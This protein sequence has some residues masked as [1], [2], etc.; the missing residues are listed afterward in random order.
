MSKFSA[1]SASKPRGRGPTGTTGRALTHEGGVGY[2]KDNKTA[3]YTLAVTDLVNEPT[4]YESGSDRAARLTQLVADVASE[5]PQWLAGFIPFLRNTAN[6]RS[7]SIVVAAEFAKALMDLRAANED[8]MDLSVRQ[9]IASAC[10]RAD[11]PA[12]MLG[13][14]MSAHGRRIPKGVKRGIAD[15][16]VKLYNEYGAIKY[17]GG[18]RGIRPADV[19]ELTH[20]SPQS[21]WQSALFKHLLDRRHGNFVSF[22]SEERDLLPKVASM[23]EIDATPEDGRRALLADPTRLSEAGYTWE[24]LSGW[25]PGG[26]DAK[27]W[28]AIIPS[29][30]YMALLRNLRNFEQAGVS[31]SMLKQVAA[32]LADPERVAKSRQFPYRFWSAF[33]ANEGSVMFGRELEE[34]LEASVSNIPELPG[35]TLVA[36]DT[37]G[38]MQSPV[39]GNSTTQC[40]EIAALFAH[41]VGKRSDAHIIQYADRWATA[42]PAASVLKSVQGVQQSIGSV[43]YGTATWPSVMSAWQKH[44]P[45]DRIIVFTDMQDHPA[46]AS[47][48]DHYRSRHRTPDL[49]DVPVYVW[50]LRGY[51]GSNVNLNQPGRYLFSGF[52]DAAFRLIPL[53]EHGLNADWPWLQD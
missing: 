51:K 12:E 42:K 38:S 28:E 52:S 43:G 7:A 2:V 50:D 39:S 11:E 53:I 19:I 23:Y 5:D 30:G 16:A 18:T 3:L 14:W 32:Q 10:S 27:A 29:M 8:V 6:M 9:V 22:S 34:A 26:M 45:F 20:P 25:V 36:M 48:H 46:Q 31:K 40:Y 44:G 13:Y 49:P 1:K 4:F 41:C 47:P 37:S 15:A 17:D 21:A 35:T 24:R 33:K